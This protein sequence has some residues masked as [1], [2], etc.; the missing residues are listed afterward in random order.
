MNHYCC[1]PRCSSWIKRDPQ[2]TFHIFPEQ[3][4]HQVSLINKFGQKERIDWRKAWILKLRIEKPVNFGRMKPFFVQ[5]SKYTGCPGIEFITGTTQ[6]LE[7]KEIKKDNGVKEDK[8]SER[9]Q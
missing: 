2:L 1:V 6:S 8:R 4:K 9:G 5:K 3:R 7:D